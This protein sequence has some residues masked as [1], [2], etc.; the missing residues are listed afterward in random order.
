[1]PFLVRRFDWWLFPDAE[2][3]DRVTVRG[4]GILAALF[5]IEV[6]FFVPL[7]R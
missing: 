2:R 6:L 1:M 7:F 5:T 4:L 3:D